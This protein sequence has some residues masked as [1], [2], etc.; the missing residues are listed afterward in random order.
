MSLDA[1]RKRE[2]SRH[3]KFG[4]ILLY[5]CWSIALSGK[6]K[7]L[8]QFTQI[9][10]M[11]NIDLKIAAIGVSD[12]TCELVTELGNEFIKRRTESNESAHFYSTGSVCDVTESKQLEKGIALV[13]SQSPLRMAIGSN[14]RRFAS[15]DMLS[16]SATKD[17]VEGR[18]ELLRA[19][20]AELLESTNSLKKSIETKITLQNLLDSMDFRSKVDSPTILHA[21]SNS[22]INELNGISPNRTQ[23]LEQQGVL[24][25]WQVGKISFTA[26]NGDPVIPNQGLKLMLD[27][28]TQTERFSTNGCYPNDEQTVAEVCEKVDLHVE[29]N[30]I[31]ERGHSRITG[32]AM[33]LTQPKIGVKEV[34]SI[35]KK[36]LNSIP[37]FNCQ[38]NVK[39]VQNFLRLYMKAVINL[40]IRSNHEMMKKVLLSRFGTVAKQWH[41][42]LT[43]NCS[44]CDVYK[45]LKHIKQEFGTSEIFQLPQEP[46]L[47]YLE[48]FKAFFR[49]RYNDRGE[50]LLAGL[51]PQLRQNVQKYLA[52]LSSRLSFHEL[53]LLIQRLEMC[54]GIAVQRLNSAQSPIHQQLKFT[55]TLMS[56]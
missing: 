9:N 20:S 43:R 55:T 48:R 19:K 42:N 23:G 3:D 47:L 17:A 51:R 54:K 53:S 13:T 34:K 18:Y 2:S 4:G 35:I 22:A 32:K 8:V 25:Q 28:E 36:S 39:T 7:N 30:Q 27:K 1:D 44:D 6:N 5:E 21:L 56:R 50:L 52:K 49:Y 12:S 38:R 46:F 45:L 16:N 41:R 11:E 37:L 10:T 15:A 40:N 26:I 31:P 24:H 29:Q 33:S 14:L